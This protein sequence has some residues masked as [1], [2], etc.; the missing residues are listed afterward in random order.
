MLQP[1]P[2]E[3][4]KILQNADPAAQIPEQLLGSL[5]DAIAAPRQIEINHTTACLSCGK[6]MTKYAAVPCHVLTCSGLA[7]A[8]H[9]PMVCTRRKCPMQNKYV[10][11]NFV[12]HEKGR[13]TWSAATARRD[14]AMLTTR[15]GV[16]WQWHAQFTRRIVHQH[17]SFLGECRAH[18]F[19]NH[20]VLHGHE[21]IANAWMKLQLLKRWPD[22][23]D[24]PF[25]L[26]DPFAAI[27]HQHLPKYNALV[28]D[29][30][31]RSAGTPLVAIIDG[32]QKMTRRTCCEQM[33]DLRSIAGADLFYV[34]ECAAKMVNSSLLFWTHIL[35]PYTHLVSLTDSVRE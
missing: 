33:A 10:W 5:A 32:D 19:A 34:Q 3:V 21:K 23:S 13:H 28:S 16:T 26:S 35:Y 2:P 20:G 25:P 6:A 11:S 12:A 4:R 24:Q 18:N 30:L 29:L 17:A 15:F 22:I 7:E 27:L 31:L 1:S 8:V 14:V 9:A